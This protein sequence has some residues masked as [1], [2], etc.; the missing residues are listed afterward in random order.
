[1]TTLTTPAQNLR[2]MLNRVRGLERKIQWSLAPKIQ[3]EG[4]A[5]Q[6]AWVLPA[7]QRPYLVFKAGVAQIE[8][9]GNDYTVSQVGD[10]YTVT[11]AVAP[12][13]GVSVIIA[14]E[15]KI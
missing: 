8:G 14:P 4:D 5:S 12:G 3:D 10:I 1:M 2:E 13:S 6:V 15:K 9:S 11:F 7:G